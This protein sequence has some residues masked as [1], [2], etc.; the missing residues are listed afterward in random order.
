MNGG[1]LHTPAA[2]RSATL[3]LCG[4]VMLGRGIDQILMRPG[5]PRLH[6]PTVKSAVEYIGLAEALTGAI[7][8]LVEPSYVWGDA[9]AAWTDID[10]AARIINLE[11]S[12]TTSTLTLAISPDFSPC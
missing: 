2:P 5:D 8:R 7:P 6:E 1:P 3:F 11:T 12:V 9:L 4:D 10:P